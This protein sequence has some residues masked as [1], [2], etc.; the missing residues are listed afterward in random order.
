MPDAPIAHDA[1]STAALLVER[2]RARPW[3]MAVVA[4]SGDDI[5]IAWDAGDDPLDASSLFQIGSIT[6]T[7][8]GVLFADAVVR[9]EAAADL[10][11]GTVL[12]VEGP[13]A[14][15]TL[16]AL[17]VQRSGLPRL[18]PNLDIGTIDQADPYAAYTEGDL[19]DALA[20]VE[21][22]PPGQL[23][24][25]FGFMTLGLAL[26]RLCGRTMPELLQERIFE[27]LGMTTA[28]CPPS[29]DGRVP[30]YAGSSRT[31]WWTTQLP[32]SGG[33]G[34]SIVDLGRYLRA[35]VDPPAGVLGEAIDL[36]TSLHTSD[37]GMGYGWTHQ[38]GGWWH[39]GGTGGFHSFVAF[40]RPTRTG[41]GLLANS[42]DADVLDK[43]G[44]A[45]LTELV[46]SVAMAAAE[47]G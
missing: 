17:A 24:S 20:A 38:G 21:I 42:G 39:N 32:G 30:G 6:K 41:V 10:T 3:G 18:P 9:G 29:E 27:P 4:I 35:H 31:P 43:V 28:G 7:M 12:G 37:P 14:A 26:R 2:V 44:F 13:A 1:T 33:V 22:G 45:T 11:L 40:H 46:R 36:A 8:T 19:L 47:A 5:E 25:N 15:I 23:Y 16:G 34:M